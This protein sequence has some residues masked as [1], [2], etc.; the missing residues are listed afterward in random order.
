MVILHLVIV[1]LRFMY[2]VKARVKLEEG[3]FFGLIGIIIFFCM[4]MCYDGT[5]IINL[6]Q[7]RLKYLD[8]PGLHEK[9]FFDNETNELGELSIL[10]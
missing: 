1:C 8:T 5:G 7:D 4:I 2:H 9:H 10:S 3:D 6:Y